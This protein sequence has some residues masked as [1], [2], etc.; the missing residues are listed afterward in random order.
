[1]KNSEEIYKKYFTF[2]I[3]VH[4]ILKSMGMLVK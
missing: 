2:E 3:P 1:M 4:M